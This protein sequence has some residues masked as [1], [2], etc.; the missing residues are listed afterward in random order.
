MYIVTF[1]NSTDNL[2][3]M[4]TTKYTTPEA[5]KCAIQHDAEFFLSTHNKVSKHDAYVGLKRKASRGWKKPATL[6]Y[7]EAKAKDG[8]SCIWQ[9]F[10]M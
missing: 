1:R 10:K 8:T 4:F 3:S 7:Y 6:D 5:A 2:T 9:Y